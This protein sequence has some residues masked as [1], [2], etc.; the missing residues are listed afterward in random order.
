MVA[1]DP[2]ILVLFLPLSQKFGDVDTSSAKGMFGSIVTSSARKNAAPAPPPV[3][4]AAFGQKK[5]PFGPPPVRRATSNSD[6]TP[7]PVQRHQQEE[8]EE[9]ETQGEWADALYD[10]ESAVRDFGIFVADLNFLN[11][12]ANRMLGIF[13]SRLISGCWLQ[14]GLRTI[15]EFIED[16]LLPVISCSDRRWTGEFNGKKGLFPASYVKIL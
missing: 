8:E 14:S 4:P 16:S 7:P 5:N 9:E 2:S 6:D 3:A 1:F 15:G 10:Y 11:E 13:V 12:L